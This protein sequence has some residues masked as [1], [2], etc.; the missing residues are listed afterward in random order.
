MALFARNERTVAAL[1]ATAS[2][3]RIE[4]S[5]LRPAIRS[6]WQICAHG[7]HLELSGADDHGGIA[8]R[9]MGGGLVRVLV[10][11]TP[12]SLSLVHNDQLEHEA[13]TFDEVW[14]LAVANLSHV[15]SVDG[16]GIANGACWVSMNADAY[17]AER[18]FVDGYLADIPLRGDIAVFHP[19]RSLLVVADPANEV[20]LLTAISLAKAEIGKPNQISLIPIVGRDHAW[21]EL[22]VP[23]SSAAHHG[24]QVLKAFEYMQQYRSQQALLADLYGT[25]V[26]VADFNAVRL[27]DEIISHCTWTKGE[28]LL[29]PAVDMISFVDEAGQPT[30]VDWDVAASIVRGRLEPTDH[31]PPRWWVDEFPSP[32]ELVRLRAAARKSHR[33]QASAPA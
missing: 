7:L 12:S 15:P 33:H 31:D 6:A 2:L 1:R 27:G 8:S 25:Q 17:A 24:L 21:R 26:V 9:A 13:V 19:T 20:S 29:L 5:T 14:P 32:Q 4:P 28:Q 23:S 16:W 10:R 22:E 3:P 11:D 18:I 30:V